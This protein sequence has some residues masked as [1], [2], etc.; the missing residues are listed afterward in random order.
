M[1]QV[2][3]V[4][5]GKLE[6]RETPAPAIQGA[7]EALVRPIV[8]GRCDLDT[9]YLTGR[10][11]L[12]NGEPIGHEIIAEI[13]ELGSRVSGFHVGQRVIVSAQISCGVCTRCKRGLTGRCEAVP[14]GASYGMGRAGNFGGGLSD[15]LRVP[16]AKAMLVPIPTQ[17]DPVRLI[18]LADMATDAWRAIAMPLSQRPGGSVMIIGGG[19]PVIGIYSAAMSISLGAGVVDYVDPDPLRRQAACAY[20][21]RVF[22]SIDECRSEYDVIVD[23]SADADR[24]LAALKRTAPEGFV[25]SVAPPLVGPSFPM[26]ELYMKGLTYRVG[27][28]NCRAGHEGALEAWSSKGFDP[29]KI[30][31]LIRPFESACETWIDPAVFV[32]VSRV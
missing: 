24:L 22:Q 28:P 4:A 29:E 7:N 19:T 27:R 13:V 9:L 5:P 15:L 14:F 21:A 23:A 32:A 8:V 26:L 6:W 16:F 17:T 1:R 11:P 3:F 20:G 25:T 18:G 10:V 12:A 30:A 2:I 31:P